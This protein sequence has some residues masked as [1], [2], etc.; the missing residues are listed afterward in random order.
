MATITECRNAIREIDRQIDSVRA[1]LLSLE[2][3]DQLS[4]ISWGEAWA[5]HPDLHE[6]QRQL[7]IRRADLN[8]ELHA[9]ERKALPSFRAPKDKKCPTCKGSGYARRAA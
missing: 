9:A 5:K 8:D 4:F 2:V 3:V 7:F 1:E 6:R